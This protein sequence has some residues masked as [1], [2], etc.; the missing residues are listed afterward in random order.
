MTRSPSGRAS[1]QRIEVAVA[2]EQSA[3]AVDEARLRRAVRI[4]LAGTAVRRAVV[5][6]AVV[7]DDTIHRLNRQYLDH[8]YA[9]D[10]LSFALDRSEDCL[11]GE[12]I[13]SADTASAAAGR[14]GW[15]AADELL[16]YVVHGVLHLAGYD[17]ILPRQRAEMR[18]RERT[19]LA[20]FGLDYRFDEAEDEDGQ[21]SIDHLGGETKS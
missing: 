11:E 8:D 7:D 17:D 21:P 20:H 15:S 2:N 1:R 18:Q 3:L 10:V 14:F 13:V 16:L 5:S 4:A 9:T 19:C 12:V 6:V